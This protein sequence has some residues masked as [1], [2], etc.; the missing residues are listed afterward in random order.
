[1]WVLVPALLWL[2]A[3]VVHFKYGQKTPKAITAGERQFDEARLAAATRDFNLETRRI[4]RDSPFRAEWE[5]QIEDLTVFQRELFQRDVPVYTPEP[6]NFGRV[7]ML[8][9]PTPEPSPPGRTSW[10]RLLEDE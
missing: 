6:L 2:G 4:M 9:A 8:S 3:I 7:R 10:A 1:M 5:P